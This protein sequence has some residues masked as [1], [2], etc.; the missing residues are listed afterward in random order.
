MKTPME[1]ERKMP[2]MLEYAS[3]RIY[4]GIVL[5]REQLRKRDPSAIMGV[6]ES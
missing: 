2:G 1:Q 4:K 5:L 3:N 6:A